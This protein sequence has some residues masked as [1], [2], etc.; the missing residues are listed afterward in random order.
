M[1]ISQENKQALRNPWVLGWLGLLVTVLA[2]NVAFIVTAFKTSPGLVDEDYYEKGRSVEEHFQRRIEARNR[3]GWD[4]NIQAPDEIMIG[5][6]TNFHVNIVDKVG[7]P[8]NDAEVSLQAY[9]PSDATADLNVKMD[10][11]SHGI[12]QTRLVLPLKGIWDLKVKVARGEDELDTSRR[13][14]VQ[15]P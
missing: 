12:Y 2:V 11:V 3:L 7:M 15:A 8:L 5:K 1:L 4:I 14:S 10:F 6:P 9:R 13:I